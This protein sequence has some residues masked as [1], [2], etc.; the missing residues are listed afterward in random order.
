MALE[1]SPLDEL[2]KLP[3]LCVPHEDT[4]YV[5][6][7]LRPNGGFF[8]WDHPYRRRLDPLLTGTLG[9]QAV[10]HARL[11]LL[12][13]T[14]Q[15]EPKDGNLDAP[16][17][18]ATPEEQFQAVFFCAA[19]YVPR[20]ALDFSTGSARTV[21]LSNWQRKRLQTSGEV[22]VESSEIMRKFFREFIFAQEVDGSPLID[23]FL[24]LVPDTTGTQKRK[25]ELAI[26]LLGTLIDPAAARLAGIYRTC[27]DRGALS[28][29]LPE[30]P[31]AFI[32]REIIG[33][34]RRSWVR[35]ITALETKLRERREQK[36]PAPL[37]APVTGLS[38]K[39]MPKMRPAGRIALMP[40]GSRLSTGSALA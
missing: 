2:T 20:E 35:I 6:Q 39:L 34:S 23:E 24:G 36:P 11:Q 19:R 31:R 22:R 29:D 30:T 9:G 18:P 16:I 25:Q 7:G 4:M 37:P 33:Y 38:P 14:D 40:W 17:L 3:L 1:R 10:R 32:G 12:H 26:A 28:P 27:L 8:D 13:R 21:F 15:H 5:L